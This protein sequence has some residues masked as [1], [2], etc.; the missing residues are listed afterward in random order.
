MTA[1]SGVSKQTIHSRAGSVCVIESACDAA[2]EAGDETTLQV[3]ERK[4]LP[5]L[6]A[7]FFEIIDYLIGGAE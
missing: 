1:F 5:I 7:E 3:E 2:K 4:A 6:S